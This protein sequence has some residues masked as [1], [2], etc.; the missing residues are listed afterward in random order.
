MARS[1]SEQRLSEAGVVHNPAIG[2]YAL[3]QFGLGYQDEAVGAAMLPLLFLVLPILLHKRTLAAVSSTQ[4]GS[5]LA[6][7][8]AKFARDNEDLLGIH[9][10]AMILKML[11]LRSIGFAVN[12]GLATIDYSTAAM[13]ANMLPPNIKRPKP[14]ERLKEFS[15]GAEKLGCWFAR[16]SISQIATALRVEF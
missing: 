7:F 2:A 16:M 3:W 8:V 13:Y 10:R 15:S 12:A 11:T 4:K 14:P 5:G 6:L 9:T 1:P